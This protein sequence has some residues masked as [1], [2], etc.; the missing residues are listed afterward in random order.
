MDETG[1]ALF[2]SPR[3]LVLGYRSDTDDSKLIKSLLQFCHVTISIL[4]CGAFPAVFT[5][6]FISGRTSACRIPHSLSCRSSATTK[7]WVFGE[8]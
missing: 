5:E 8:F 2:M 1:A 6:I 3:G 4:W 7:T